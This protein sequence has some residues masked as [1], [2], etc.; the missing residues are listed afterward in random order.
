MEYE[1]SSVSQKR[2]ENTSPQI[3]NSS[4]KFPTHKPIQ[5][6]QTPREVYIPASNNTP[7]LMEAPDYSGT[8]AEIERVVAEGKKFEA[9]YKKNREYEAR[10][11][12]TRSYIKSFEMMS[13][14]TPMPQT[15]YHIPPS[16]NHTENSGLSTPKFNPNTNPVLIEVEGYYKGNGAYVKPHLRTAP[17]DRIT[18]NMRY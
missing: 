14:P 16:P 1:P 3:L 17:N 4:D 18:D 7:Y 5:T 12:E 8:L 15:D 6:Y 13:V 11:S 2:I 9:E 10:M